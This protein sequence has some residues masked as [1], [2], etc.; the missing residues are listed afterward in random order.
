MMKTHKKW[1][2]VLLVVLTAFI[3]LNAVV[4]N[5]YTKEIL[6]FKKYYNGGLDRMG[7]I[8]GSKHYRNPG[9]TLSRR[10]MNNT[11]YR[12]QKVDVVTIGDSFSNV[13]DNGLNP[14][15]QDW[16]A[17]LYALDVLNVQPLP[18]QNELTSVLIMLNSGYLDK[19]KPR[20]LV[21]EKVERNCLRE[22]CPPVDMRMAMPLSEV[23]AF[24]K[25]AGFVD[26]PP[27]VGFINTGNVK[28]LLNSLL[29]KFSDRA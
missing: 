13:K 5:L 25:N 3:G 16:I 15:Y 19:V 20:F 17:S 9:F 26:N 12:G 18:G 28:F 10:H 2:L 29:Y 11:D 21:L 24:F 1:V 22:F 4:W 14:L 27:D 8:I 6:T 7:Y 23:E